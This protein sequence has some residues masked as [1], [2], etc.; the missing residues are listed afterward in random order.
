MLGSWK[1][2]EEFLLGC[3][4]TQVRLAPLKP[5]NAP[6]LFVDLNQGPGAVN[7][8]AGGTAVTLSP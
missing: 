4:H 8:N 6:A 2:R 5:P 1:T 7:V 3:D